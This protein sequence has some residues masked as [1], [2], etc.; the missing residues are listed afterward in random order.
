[1]KTISFQPYEL[2]RAWLPWERFKL[3]WI[4]NIFRFILIPERF[5]DQKDTDKQLLLFP[6]NSVIDIF[7]SLRFY[8]MW[9]SEITLFLGLC[10]PCGTIQNIIEFKIYLQ[11]ATENVIFLSVNS[12]IYCRIASWLLNSQSTFI[13]L[14]ICLHDRQ[15]SESSHTTLRYIMFYDSS[16]TIW[17]PLVNVLGGNSPE[18]NP[19]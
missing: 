10:F 19:I 11:T 1:M 14:M 7:H 9:K 3:L 6:T 15:F 12:N 13:F 17:F 16:F 8:F 5:L 18:C 4:P 2:F